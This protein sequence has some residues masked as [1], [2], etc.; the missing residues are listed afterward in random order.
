MPAPAVKTDFPLKEGFRDRVGREKD[1][2]W[3]TGQLHYLHA[4]GGIWVIR[5]AAPEEGD[6]FGGKLVLDI[7]FNMKNFREGDL[8]SVRGKVVPQGHPSRLVGGPTY[9]VDHIDMIERGEP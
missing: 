3:L 4:E 5:Y 1:F 7:P 6:A 2:S 8:V 9:R